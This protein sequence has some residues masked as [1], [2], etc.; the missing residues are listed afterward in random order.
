[1]AKLTKENFS[2]NVE[3]NNLENLLRNLGQI[4]A[5]TSIFDNFE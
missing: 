2:V 4:Q 3:T 5:G 1:L